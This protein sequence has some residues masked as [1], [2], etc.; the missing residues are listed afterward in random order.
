MKEIVG[1]E[2]YEA[3]EEEDKEENNL[4]NTPSMYVSKNSSEIQILGDKEARVQSRR[5]FIGSSSHLVF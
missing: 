3:S 4:K 1:K 2:E 5:N